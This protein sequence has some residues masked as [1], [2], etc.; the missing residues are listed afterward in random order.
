MR[1]PLTPL[2]ETEFSHIVKLHREKGIIH[3]YGNRSINIF[4]VHRDK[5]HGGGL[6]SFLAAAGKRALPF[7]K[8]HILPSAQKMG[9]KVLTDIISGQN[10]KSSIRSRSKQSLQDIGSSILTEGSK[11]YRK[12]INSFL[13]NLEF[14]KEVRNVPI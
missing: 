9:K 10:I 6:F 3:G 13:G 7:L 12:K 5:I 14:L 4:R 1:I 11:R 8:R 2:S